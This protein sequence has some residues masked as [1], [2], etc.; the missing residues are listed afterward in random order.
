MTS[1]PSLRVRTTSVGKYNDIYDIQLCEHEIP[2][3][4]EKML[5]P[6]TE[7]ILTKPFPIRGKFYIL[8][9]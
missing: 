8:F 4:T 9:Y 1:S 2:A 6:T 7:T 3:D 5:P